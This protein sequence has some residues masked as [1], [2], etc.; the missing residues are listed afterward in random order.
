M[1]ELEISGAP[2]FGTAPSVSLEYCVHHVAGDVLP[3][4]GARALNNGPRPRK[5]CFSLAFG[6]DALCFG[7]QVFLVKSDDVA[8]CDGLIPGAEQ[9]LADEPVGRITGRAHTGGIVLAQPQNPVPGCIRDRKS[10]AAVHL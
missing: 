2:A 10:N 9:S 3:S 6:V 8:G 4:R 1:V 5:L 7:D